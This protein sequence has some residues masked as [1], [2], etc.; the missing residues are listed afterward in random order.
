MFWKLEL[1]FHELT[2]AN[3]CC[4]PPF[5]SLGTSVLNLSRCETSFSQGAEAVVSVFFYVK[6]EEDPSF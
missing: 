3:G 4:C 5:L 6:T 1:L 2:P